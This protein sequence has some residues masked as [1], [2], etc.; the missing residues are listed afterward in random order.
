MKTIHR[1]DRTEHEDLLIERLIDLLIGRNL[2]L[3]YGALNQQ[4]NKSTINKSF[5]LCALSGLCGELPSSTE[6]THG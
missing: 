1:G 5:F 6:V 2:T 4:I 3:A